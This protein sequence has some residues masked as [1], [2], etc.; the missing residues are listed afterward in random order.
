MD[1]YNKTATSSAIM[2]MEDPVSCGANHISATGAIMDEF[3]EVDMVARRK[4]V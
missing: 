1:Q 2:R 3:A 4:A